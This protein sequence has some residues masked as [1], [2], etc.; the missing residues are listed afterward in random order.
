[1]G[2]KVFLCNILTVIQ[3]WLMLYIFYYEKAPLEENAT[4]SSSCDV[5]TQEEEWNGRGGGGVRGGD[6]ERE[7]RGGEVRGRGGGG[8]EGVEERGEGVGEGSRRMGQ[9]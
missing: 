2:Y 1:M 5:P 4:I 9:G 6:R 8:G 7:G 3:N